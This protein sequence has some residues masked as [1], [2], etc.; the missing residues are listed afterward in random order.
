MHIIY[1]LLVGAFATS[2]AEYHFDYNLVDLIKDK[3]VGL[4]NK[5]EGKL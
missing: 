2:F 4:F 5:V 1:A 3:V